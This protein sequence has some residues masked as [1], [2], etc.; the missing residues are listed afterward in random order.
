MTEHVLKP[1]TPV[2]MG[3]HLGSGLED[4]PDVVLQ[5]EEDTFDAFLRLYGHPPEAWEWTY[6]DDGTHEFT[7]KGK[8]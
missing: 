8:A 5:V 1:G 6:H 7:M 3:A 2:Q 4:H